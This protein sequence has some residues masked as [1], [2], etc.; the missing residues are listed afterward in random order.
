MFRKS[1]SNRTPYLLLLP[2]FI[3]V[4]AAA[5]FTVGYLFRMS[6]VDL[7]FG[8]SWERAESVGFKNYIW[9]LRNSN[10]PIWNSL[11]VTGIYS[12]G[13]LLVELFL[14]FGLGHLFTK[15]IF[16]RSVYTAFLIIPMVIM[17][18]M[19]GMIGRLYFSFDGLVNYFMEILFG[20]KINWNSNQ[21]AL[22]A[23]MIV[24][25]WEWTPFFL[26]ILLAGLQSLPV[27]PFE[28]A[29]VDGASGWQIFKHLTLPLMAP[30]ILVASILR[31]MD[32]LRIFDVIY[33]MFGG[34]PG[35]ATTILPILVWRVTMVARDVGRG[36][37][38][39]VMLIILIVCFVIILN[40]LFQKVRKGG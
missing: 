22:F 38:I 5:T 20:L 13:T 23:A 33:V 37:A 19:V 2:A 21:L 10:S 26:L 18:S 6:L 12:I 27:E 28:A 16:G 40:K 35:S 24:D 9:L 7:P 4:F 17:P 15:K 39:S 1:H 14:G 11:K 3:V 36:S 30:L 29:K 8:A 32:I 25:I 31:F 34:G